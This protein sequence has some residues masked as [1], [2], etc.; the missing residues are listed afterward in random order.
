MINK[1]TENEKENGDRDY[2]AYTRHREHKAAHK[3]APA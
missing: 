2:G 3:F 1:I